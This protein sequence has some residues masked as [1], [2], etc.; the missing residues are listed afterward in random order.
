MSQKLSPVKGG[1]ATPPAE[2]PLGIPIADKVTIRE[3]DRNTADRVYEN[4][5]SYLPRGRCGWHYGVYFEGEIVG[6]ISFDN[7]PSQSTI[8]GYDSSQIIEVSRVC[9]AHDTPNLA[10]CAMSKAQ[11]TFTKQYT[12]RLELLITY[13]KDGYHGTMFKAL[14]GKGWEIDGLSCGKARAPHH[15][16]GE[17]HEIYTT[18]K[19]RWVCEV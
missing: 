13:V 15:E 5:H 6:S 4:H 17:I 12:D 10:S 19:Q 9:I 11:N 8:R 7:W 3:I 14:R 16:T 18:D 1:F 2:Y